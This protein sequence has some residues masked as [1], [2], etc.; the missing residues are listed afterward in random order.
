[1][2][3]VVHTGHGGYA[4]RD[5][6]QKGS[7]TM[8]TTTRTSESTAPTGGLLLAFELAQRP[9]SS[10]SSKSLRGPCPRTCPRARV[11]SWPRSAILP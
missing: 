6:F 10:L 4:H 2:Q 5:V 1:M 9:T 8:I 7:V 11:R 3:S